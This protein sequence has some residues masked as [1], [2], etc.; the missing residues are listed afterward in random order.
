MDAKDEEYISETVVFIKGI[1]TGD[2]DSHLEGFEL[3]DSASGEYYI[4][5]M[6]ARRPEMIWL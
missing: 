2:S 5:T 1:F 6:R 3:H 4:S